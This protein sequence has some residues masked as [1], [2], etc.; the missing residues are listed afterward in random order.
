MKLLKFFTLTF[1]FSLIFLHICQGQLVVE[2]ISP[3]NISNWQSSGEGNWEVVPNNAVPGPKG[4]SPK[5]YLYWRPESKASRGSL[6][7]NVFVIDKAFQ[8]FDIAGTW[9]KNASGTLEYNRIRLIA[10]PG[11]ELLRE[12]VTNNYP[13]LTTERWSTNDLIGK[14]VQLEIL[15]PPV[16]TFLGESLEWMALENYRQVGS[17]LLPDA[18]NQ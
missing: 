6:R 11:G 15:S 18:L 10:Y 2:S 7:S 14:K 3:E 16:Y 17:E 13:F 12:K 1:F 9:G 4:I 8:V 5:Y